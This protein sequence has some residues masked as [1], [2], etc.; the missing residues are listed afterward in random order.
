MNFAREKEEGSGEGKGLPPSYVQL[1]PI[2]EEGRVGLEDL[3]QPK[4]WLAQD[5]TAPIFRMIEGHRTFLCGIQTGSESSYL[6]PVS[7]KSN[8]LGLGLQVLGLC[9]V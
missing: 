8:D 3:Q 2:F 4:Q 9:D 7:M 5:V 6:R 1:V